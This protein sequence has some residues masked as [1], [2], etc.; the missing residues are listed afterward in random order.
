MVL[1]NVCSN[2]AVSSENNGSSFSTN[3]G[4][5]CRV[6]QM[7]ILKTAVFTLWYFWHVVLHIMTARFPSRG[8]QKGVRTIWRTYR[9]V[10]VFGNCS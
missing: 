4:D 6:S 2:S 9:H 7:V 5:I 1:V 10:I 3:K 8:V